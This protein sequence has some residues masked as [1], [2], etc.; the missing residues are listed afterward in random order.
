MAQGLRTIVL[1]PGHGGEDAG[2]RGASVVEKDLTLL[3]ARRVKAAIENRL[4]IRVLMTRDSDETLAV[5]RR[6]AF[7]NHNKADLF[8]SLHA[9]ASVRST[10]RGAQVLTLDVSNY[11]KLAADSAA[12]RTV[13]LLGGGT[14]VID[15]V[16]WELAQLPFAEQSTTFASLVLQ[17]FGEKSVTLFARPSATAPLRVLAGANMPAVILELGFLTNADDEAALSGAEGQNSIVEAILAA[18]VDIRRGFAGL[19]RHRP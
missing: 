10:A 15:P 8:I 13:P 11:P 18:I 16:P 14:R 17:H 7:A 6:A 12:P 5:D 1:D 4:G 19:E 9:N 2:S 3:I